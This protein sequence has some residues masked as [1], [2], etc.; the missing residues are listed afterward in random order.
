M[1]LKGSDIDIELDEAKN[2]FKKLDLNLIKVDK[3]N[4]PKDKGERNIL[5]IKKLK[6]TKTLYPRQYAKIKKQPL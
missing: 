5:M 6:K 4:L 2:A 1:P 3:Y